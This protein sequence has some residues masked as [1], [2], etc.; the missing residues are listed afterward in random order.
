VASKVLNLKRSGLDYLLAKYFD[1]QTGK[2]QGTADWAIRP[3]PKEMITY[4]ADDVRYLPELRQILA[5]AARSEA[6]LKE[7]FEYLEEYREPERRYNPDHFIV[8]PGAQNLNPIQLR[9]LKEIYLWR[10]KE[11]KQSNTA[12]FMILR[13]KKLVELAAANIEKVEDIKRIIGKGTKPARR[14]S[15]RI[16]EVITTARQL[17]PIDPYSI[18]NRKKYLP[19]DNNESIERTYRSQKE[20]K[21]R[22]ALFALRNTLAHERHHRREFIFPDEVIKRISQLN[23]QSVA[24]LPT[25]KGFGAWRINQYGERI[26]EKIKDANQ[27]YDCYLCHQEIQEHE[28]LAMC[29]YC[30]F[31]FHINGIIDHLKQH[32]TCPHCLHLLDISQISSK[33]N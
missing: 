20:Q 26:I 13:K 25:L 6:E 23:P 8:L 5:D 17:E 28:V 15:D 3:L 9:I 4:A 33:K 1:K 29:P 14:Y 21:R 2:S 31:R 22:G 11:A 19:I 12:L 16:Y 24:D 27:S 7:H 10:L 32:A 30:E 18:Q